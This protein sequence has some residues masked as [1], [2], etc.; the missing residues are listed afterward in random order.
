[1]VRFLH[2]GDWQLGMTRH[3][4]SDGAQERFAQ[5]RFDA[6][7]KIGEL[8]R[9]HGAEFVVVCGDVFETNQVDRKTV[10]RA[11]D[12]LASISVPVYLLPGNHD[13]LDAG[14]IFRQPTFTQRRPSHVHVLTS[15]EILL[16]TPTCELIAA[17][18]TSKRPLEDLVR[19]ATRELE[20]ARGQTRI[21][22]AH[23]AVDDLSPN[24]DDPAVIE[25]AAAERALAERRVHYI[26]LGDRHSLTPVG[27]TRRIWYA[28]AP[29]PTDFR[30]TEPGFVLFVDV[31]EDVVETTPLATARWSFE[32]REFKLD[33]DA[34][35]DAFARDLAAN[36][37]K[38]RT[39]LKLDLRGTLTLKQKARLDDH[40]EELER[41]YAA[42]PIS[43]R[44]FEI[45]VLPE[46]SDF[47]QIGL[48]GFAAAAVTRLR[49]QS[50]AAGIEGETA[51]A[52]LGLLVRLAE[53]P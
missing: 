47:E 44:R 46:D 31:T 13:P 5:A 41:V 12:A 21:V 34:D 24:R 42:V 18:W 20:P 38:A 39:V 11:L 37:N 28:G 4:F 2:T 16:A 7:T 29:E 19:R 27:S 51:R 9:E 1:M 53:R 6:I 50:R 49:E 32:R 25:L 23:G 43:E 3:F 40:L 10:S 17:P 36:P 35:L 30:E 15:S 8:A 52:A 33:S 48:S 22:V 14:S 45:A 26:A